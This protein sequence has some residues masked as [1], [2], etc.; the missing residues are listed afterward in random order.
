MS[1]TAEN[2]NSDHMN[3]MKEV[4]GPDEPQQLQ[5]QALVF[6]STTP[7]PNDV[8]PSSVGGEEHLML[9]PPM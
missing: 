2:L 3:A 9:M 4:F 8:D 1:V 7:V 6:P 5:S